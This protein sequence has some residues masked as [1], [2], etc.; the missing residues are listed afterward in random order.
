MEKVELD[1]F[2]KILMPSHLKKH[3]DDYYFIGSRGNVEDNRYE[4]DI[5]RVRDGVMTM[6]TTS[7]QVASF[8]CRADGLYF[9]RPDEKALKWF[10]ETALCMIPYDGGE[11]R[12]VRKWPYQVSSIKWIDDQHWILSTT[13]NLKVERLVNSGKT[14]QEAS[15]IMENDL[16][17]C[18]EFTEVPFWA[19]GAGDV[20]EMRSVLVDWNGEEGK[21]ITSLDGQARLINVCGHTAYIRYATYHDGVI[22]RKASIITYDLDS[23]TKK[24]I[25]LPSD[26]AGIYGIWEAPDSQL[27]LEISYQDKDEHPNN[28]GY[29]LYDGELHLIYSG[30]PYPLGNSEGSDCMTG[31]IPSDP[32]LDDSGIVTLLTVENHAALVK[33]N[34]SGYYQ[35]LTDESVMVQEF[36]P[37]EDGFAALLMKDSE[38]SALYHIGDKLTAI[39]NINANIS[40]EYEL[41]KPEEI[42]FVNEN[43]LT[44]KGWVIFPNEQKERY[45]A[46]LDI[47]GGPQTVYGARLFHE[48]QYWAQH[49]YAVLFTNPTGSDGRGDD[50]ANIRGHYGTTDYRDLMTF[51]DT[52][53]AKYP[54]IDKDRLGVTGGSYGGFMTNWIIGHTDR[55]KAAASQ[56]SIASWLIFENTSDIGHT[57]GTDQIGGNQWD[58]LDKLWEQSPIH[59][60]PNVKTPTL[61]I[62][63]DE[64]T[65]CWMGEGISMFYALK[66]YG[67]ESKLCLFKQENHELSRS[68]RPQNRMRRLKEI[69]A[70]MDRYLRPEEN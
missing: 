9:L 62:H 30:N 12:E 37:E 7:H 1:F 49:G 46:I 41:L 15:E 35:A 65:R 39:A 6:M 67:V 5:Y 4:K 52:V 63:S 54:Q 56:R 32:Y 24:T 53:L 10:G 38:P 45:P 60:A 28:S 22:N 19:N 55:F 31:N 61:F 69:T 17:Q 47:H 44:I 57:F 8:E 42:E 36:I 70:W 29:Y 40:D 27:L 64:D 23:E 34:Y 3:G 2:A 16:Q 48:M 33:I 25:E 58:N 14:P 66:R 68:G 20:S 13:R 51:V 11:T 43:G 50:F 59:Y 26:M 18:R 21:D